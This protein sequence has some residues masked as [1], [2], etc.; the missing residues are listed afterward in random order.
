MPTRPFGKTGRSVSVFG[1]GCFYV[2]A[3]SS[4]EDG[5]AV[6]RRALDLGC[7]YFDT[8]PSY[9]SGLSEKRVGM[10]LSGRRDR[11]FL[12]TKTLERQGPSARR[13]LEAS[14][15]RLRTDHVDMIQVHCVTD[16]AN[17]EQVLSD[18]GP[19]PALLRA[20]EQGLARFIGVTGHQD[21]AVVRAAIERW[22]WDCV[23]MPLN[24]V[25]LHW[26]SF[27]TGA[28]PAAVT[29]GIARVAMKVFSSGRLVHGG[30]GKTLSAEDCL[31]FAYGLDVSCAVVGCATVAEVELAARVAVEGKPLD[32]S[33]K[34]AL[35]E[36]AKPFSGTAPPRGVE[37]Y[38]RT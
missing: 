7:T 1:L 36:E 9:V 18:R 37:W 20:K 6:V 27:V 31:R 38:K 10:G 14:L 2:G 4:D 34:K 17:L 11:V 3:A 21:P 13:E 30:Q 25:D 12:S 16:A 22:S 15:K 8:A 33:R 5:V 23:L 32:E 24:P 28:R 35:V 26:R 19:L 29:A